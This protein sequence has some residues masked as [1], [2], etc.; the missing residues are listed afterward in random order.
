MAGQIWG[1]VTQDQRVGQE[2]EEG[3]VLDFDREIVGSLDILGHGMHAMR[4]RS[5]SMRVRLD[6][7][8]WCKRMKIWPSDQ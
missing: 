2:L 1:C 8:G 5:I 6:L 3:A 4:C 7:P